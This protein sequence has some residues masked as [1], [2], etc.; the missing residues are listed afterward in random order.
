[1]PLPP[2]ADDGMTANVLPQEAAEFRREGMD[3]RVDKP[4]RRDQLLA[5]VDYG[6]DSGE[7]PAAQV[8][9][10]RGTY[11]GLLEIMGADGM[12]RLLDCL[13]AQL[14]VGC[15]GRDLSP[16]ERDRLAA[17]AHGLVSAAGMLGFH[18]LS[19]ACRELEEACR[20]G[21]DLAWALARFQAKRGQALDQIASLKAA[22]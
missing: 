8:P 5:T 18:A 1:M 17:D 13:A 9:F 20:S 7:E 4:F 11:D 3:D 15:E 12:N 19:Q 22:A 10:H 16:A 21:N 2:G 6:L 14:E